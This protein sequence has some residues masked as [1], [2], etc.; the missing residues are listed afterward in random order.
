MSNKNASREQT[1]EKSK[2]WKRAPRK[3]NER[4]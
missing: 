4:N 2:K 1:L 3:E